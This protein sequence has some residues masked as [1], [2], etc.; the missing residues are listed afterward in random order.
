MFISCPESIR[1]QSKGALLVAVAL[2]YGAILSG[3]TATTQN[4]NMYNDNGG[5][6]MALD[7]RDFQQAAGESVDSMLRS[8]A[9]N[10]QGGGRYVLA[11]SRIIN[12]TMQ[13]IDTDQ[14]VKKI[15][16]ELLQSGKVV[17]TTAVGANG[18]EDRMSMQARELRK[19]DEFNQK[20][21]AKKGQMIAPDLSLSGKIIQRNVRISKGKQQVE[22]YFQLTLTDINSG[23]A[24]W[25]GESVIGKRG[26]SKS[27][28]W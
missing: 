2:I 8:G 16:V 6:V 10:K 23:L 4:I 25:E 22:Y 27:V 15:R 5:A 14:L 24:F 12:D 28:S 13:R 21:V 9:L 7:Y 20:T 19:S 18:A 1:K 26:S 17:V 11:V 3:C